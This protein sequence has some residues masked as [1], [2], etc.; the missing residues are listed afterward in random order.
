[1]WFV[2][3]VVYFLCGLLLLLFSSRVVCYCYCCC[4]VAVWFVIVL[5]YF[6]LV[7]YC[8]CL[9]PVWLVIVV[10]YFLCG[11]LL[12]LF[13]SCVDGIWSC[14]TKE[15]PGQ[16]SVWGEGHFTS[17]DRLGFRKHW[18]NQKRRKLNATWTTQ[19]THHKIM[20]SIFDL[21]PVISLKI[22]LGQNF[23]ENPLNCYHFYKNGSVKTIKLWFRKTTVR[24]SWDF[25]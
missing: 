24:L 21:R 18:N 22:G 4:L 5:V 16:C 13:S 3:V 12:L 15:C 8:C 6:M 7:C 2:I 19:L 14:S 10:V 25:E 20:S 23:V 11:L 1:M 9:F 17:F